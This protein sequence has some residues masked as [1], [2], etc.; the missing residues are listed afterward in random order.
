[1]K[2]IFTVIVLI[3][4]SIVFTACGGGSSGSSEANNVSEVNTPVQN[5][6]VSEPTQRV[7][8]IDQL[9]TNTQD[10]QYNIELQRGDQI[11]K[12]D[13]NTVISIFHGVNGLKTACL[14]SGRAQI[15]RTVKS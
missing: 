13:E 7:I 6:E 10:A 1:M 2:N 9:C 3:V 15:L 14:V 5:P 4:A 11:V 8:E 12:V